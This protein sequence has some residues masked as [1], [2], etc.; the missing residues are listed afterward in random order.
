MLVV[1]T[2]DSGLY[3]ALCSL[4]LLEVKRERVYNILKDKKFLRNALYNI[5]YIKAMLK[6]VTY[7]GYKHFINNNLFFYILVFHANYYKT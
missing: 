3:K 6:L 2:M 1:N 5:L 4:F 7:L